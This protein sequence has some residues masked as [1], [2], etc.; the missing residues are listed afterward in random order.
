[1]RNLIKMNTK[2]L[3]IHGE[4]KNANSNKLFTTINPASN[5]VICQVQEA[6]SEDID[7]AVVSAKKGF[8]IWS[9]MTGAERGAVL[10]KAANLLRARNQ[11]IAEL[12]VMDTGKPIQEAN[13]VDI[14]SGADSIDY[15]AGVAPSIH[16][17]H[18]DLGGSFAYTRREPLG[19][20]AGIG[21][22]NY[23]IQIACWKSAPALACGN[24]MIF[25]P[26][27]L[28]PL[29]AYKLAEIYKEA[30][31]PDG[32]FNLV[33]GGEQTGKLLTKHR[34]IQKI[35]FTGEVDTGKK[36]LA[37]IANTMKHTTME[38]GGKSPLII[39]EDADVHNAVAGAMMA[40][41]YTQGEVCS[42]ATRVFVAKSIKKQFLELLLEKTKKMIIGDPTHP[43]TQ[44][45]ALISEEHLQKV[46]YYIKQG[47]KEGAKLLV[48]GNRVYPKNCEQG[49][50]VE[51]T[52]FDHCQDSFTIV[53]EEIFG[54]VM[55]VLEFDDQDE[56]G[57]IARANNTI[58]G[59]SSGV[60]TKNIQRGHRVA[61]ALEAGI[62]WIN[63]YNVTPIEMPFGGYKHSGIGRENSLAAIQHYTQLKSVY[64]EM[65]NVDCPY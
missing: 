60:F 57:V 11:E 22:W 30:G 44:V 51:P 26:S 5:Q 8:A 63:N 19:V 32:V 49:F 50:F 61:A 6:G 40:N 56:K 12:E 45:G 37:D 53:Q 52:V 58:Y 29:S 10:K 59:L 24:S 18:F 17:N 23:P 39:F 42:N 3:F 43:D 28:T 25:K 31:L 33:Q 54:P 7:L 62:C 38:L 27:E 34:G 14:L 9:K 64:V 41:F 20:C 15:F 2:K 1:M 47:K 35:S 4:Y 48:G 16:G 46:L 36:I 13:V 55:S 21:A 65:G